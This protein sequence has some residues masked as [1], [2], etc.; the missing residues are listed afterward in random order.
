MIPTEDSNATKTKHNNHTTKLN[1]W[2]LLN[3]LT[4]LNET[5]VLSYGLKHS[6]TPKQIPTEVIVSSVEAALSR[7]RELS[8]ATKDNIRSRIASTLQ[9]ASQHIVSF[10]GSL[11]YQLSKYLTTIL[12]PLTD[13]SRRKLQST[14]DFINATKILQIPDDYKVVSFDV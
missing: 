5:R 11:T 3:Y 12:Q 7:Q 6:V 1:N 4:L 13:K 14:E 10:C 8:E 9:S 2:Y